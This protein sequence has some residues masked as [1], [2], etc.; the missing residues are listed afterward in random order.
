MF[1]ENSLGSSLDNKITNGKDISRLPQKPFQNRKQK[2][3]TLQKVKTALPNSPIKRKQMIEVIV[4][5]TWK[6]GKSLLLVQLTANPHQGNREIQP[7]HK[8]LQTVIQKQ[9]RILSAML[10]I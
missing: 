2:L 9:I 8:D 3:R 7:R 6:A 10:G 1:E 5:E 4:D